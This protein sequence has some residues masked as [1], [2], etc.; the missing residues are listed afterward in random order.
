[1]NIEDH[2]KKCSYKMIRCPLWCNKKF[3]DME[4]LEKRIPC[5]HK[6]ILGS[7]GGCNAEF[8]RCQLEDHLSNCVY[9]PLKDAFHGINN[10][11]TALER[12]MEII[13][14]AHKEE[15]DRLST[16]KL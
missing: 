14:R 9:E 5:I 15:L 13:Q 16:L 4:T 7:Y 6:N 3:Y 11:M 8:E 12:K 10:H 1:K 2:R